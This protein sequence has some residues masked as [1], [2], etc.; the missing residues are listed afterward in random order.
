MR[1]F[2]LIAEEWNE[3]RSTPIPALKFFLPLLP[4]GAA[5]LDA[6]CGNGRNARVIA[7]NSRLLYCLDSSEKMLAFARK[8]L[9]GIRNV[10]FVKAGITKL[11]LPSASLD[12][13]FYM[14][15][16]HH[17]PKRSQNAAF[18]E[19][20][21]VLKKGGKAFITVWNKDQRKFLEQRSKKQFG[22][23]WKKKDGTNVRRFH[24]FYTA[25]ELRA[26]AKRNGMRA[27][28]VFYECKGKKAEKKGAY[29]LCAVFS[30]A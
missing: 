12:V 5:A 10:R 17:L 25:A 19:M 8:N 7:R 24:Y 9:R 1:A 29:N 18:R 30:R 15:V 11:P 23:M 3:R 4:D 28:S 21:R 13:A 22:V 6:G 26:I 27:E 20:A 14:A 16:L 2:D